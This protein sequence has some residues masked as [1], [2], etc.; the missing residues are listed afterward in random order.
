MAAVVSDRVWR[1]VFARDAAVL[2]ERIRVNGADYE[3]V[4]V[5]AEDFR[6]LFNGGLTPTSVWLPMG[7]TWGHPG[8]EAAGSFDPE[9]RHRRWVMVQGRLAPEPDQGAGRGAGR[10]HR[11][12]ARRNPGMLTAGRRPQ[13]D[14][15]CPPELAFMRV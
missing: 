13:P 5:V 8:F 7:A 15:R 11:A 9:S 10:R 6:G 12:T 1:Q 2:G 3:I 4:G 14:E